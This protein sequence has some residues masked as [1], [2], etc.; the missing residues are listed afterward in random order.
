MTDESII[1]RGEVYYITYSNNTLGSEQESGRPAVV[2]SNNSN[3]EHSGCVEICYLTLQEKKPLP[4]HVKVYEGVCSNS[5]ILCEQVTTI[6]KKR[7]G[8]FMCRLSDKIMDEVDLALATS[9]GI[10]YLIS[11]STDSTPTKGGNTISTEQYQELSL[12]HI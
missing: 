8:D 4:T 2:V 6:S 3:N 7:I 12:I 5:T 10:D 1:R 9:L 11:D